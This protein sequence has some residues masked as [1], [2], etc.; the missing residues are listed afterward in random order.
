[1]DKDD[2]LIIRSATEYAVETDEDEAEV[3]VDDDEITLEV[4]L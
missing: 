3:I 4:D 1:M 2:V